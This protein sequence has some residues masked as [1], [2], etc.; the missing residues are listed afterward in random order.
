MEG[1]FRETVKAE[2]NA[3]LGRPV[4]IR[5]FVESERLAVR[6]LNSNHGILSSRTMRW[7]S[8][9]GV[10]DF[11]QGT[12][13]WFP[14]KKLGVRSSH[15]LIMGLRDLTGHIRIE[16]WTCDIREIEGLAAVNNDVAAYQT[17]DEFA[18]A[19]CQP[20][21]GDSSEPTLRQ[22]LT[23]EEIRILN[24]ANGGGDSF[25]RFLWDGE[26]TFLLNAG[27]AHHF[28]AAR[29]IA[30]KLAVKV[31]LTGRLDIYWIR[32]DSVEEVVREYDIY[33]LPDEAVFSFQEAM[34][35][36]GASYGICQAP[37]PLHESVKL[38]LLSRAERR[39][40][41]ASRIL[42][43]TEVFDVGTYLRCVSSL[44]QTAATQLTGR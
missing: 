43:Q 12:V 44:P 2:I 21:I 24:S 36:F 17:L 7:Q 16:G 33:A 41:H 34:R 32:W 29:Y 6:F 1:S 23:H 30:G 35:S 18:E 37:Y 3:A 20:T 14:A 22:N 9:R 13:R 19:K 5:R 26:R 15:R 8:W 28:S 11:E 42:S 38:V 25:A 4:A 39:S 40:M 10:A 27:G 31:P